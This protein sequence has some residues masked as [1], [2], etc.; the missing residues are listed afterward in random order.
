[1]STGNLQEDLVVK[2]L[3]TLGV[4][5]MSE[6][7]TLAFL[8]CHVAS[9]GTAAQIARSIGYDHVEIGAALQRLEAL[10]LIQRSR[11]SQGVRMY[12]LSSA[13]D[14]SPRSSLL[15][16]MSLAL[17]RTGRVLLLK[18]LKCRRNEP[19]RKSDRGLRLA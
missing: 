17:N 13:T 4:E 10:N 3:H 8:H 14:P 2:H 7:D 12:Q 11:A 18:H 6:W 5:H 9:L 16:L 1:L 15:A 19:Q